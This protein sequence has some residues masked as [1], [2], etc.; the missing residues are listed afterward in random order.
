MAAA[1]NATAQ[2]LLARIR[3]VV[4]HGGRQDEHTARPDSM[5]AAIFQVKFAGAGE[6]VQYRS[7]AGQ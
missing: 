4:P 1:K 5:L 7:L 2:R 3:E 6:D